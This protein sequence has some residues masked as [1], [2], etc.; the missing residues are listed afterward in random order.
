MSAYSFL[1]VAKSSD[2]FET[3][4]EQISAA[5][6]LKVYEDVEV[7]R[8]PVE[9]SVFI[10]IES[11]L[12]LDEFDWELGTAKGSLQFAVFFNAEAFEDA[13]RTYENAWIELDLSGLVLP[14]S[15]IEMLAPNASPPP[16]DLLTPK[17]FGPKIRE[18]GPGRR[19]KHD[20]DSALISL[21]G[22]AERNSIAADPDA[23]GAQA[24]IATR[25]ADWFATRDLPIPGNSQLQERARDILISI[26]AANP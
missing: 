25:L 9:G 6:A 23:H 8:A 3:T 1:E 26:R 24:D 18:G 19:R 20:W 2:I 4:P 5:K 22:E 21:I 7:D 16:I 11:A 14:L 17:S 10:P 12:W 15:L 13:L